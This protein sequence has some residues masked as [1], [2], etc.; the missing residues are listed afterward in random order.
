PRTQR[1]RRH[2]RCAGAWPASSGP[3]KL[4]HAGLNRIRFQGTVSIRPAPGADGYPRFS[5][6]W[7]PPGTPMPAMAGRRGSEGEGHAGDR[8]AEA[9]VQS[10]GAIGAALAHVDL[11]PVVADMDPEVVGE[12][13]FHQ[14][15]G[16]AQVAVVIAE[17]AP[18]RVQVLSLQGETPA[19]A[20]RPIARTSRVARP[21]RARPVVP[22]PRV[23]ASRR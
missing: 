19:L 13:V 14:R 6:Y 21:L 23:G 16:A 4:P 2:P 18:V 20:A 15:V 12:A 5:G 10:D 3:A 17:V 22:A 8:A 1:R 9:L 11:E 7:T